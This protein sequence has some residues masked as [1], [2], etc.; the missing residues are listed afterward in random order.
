M[1]ARWRRSRSTW[2]VDPRRQRDGLLAQAVQPGQDDAGHGD[3]FLQLGG[4]T[5]GDHRDDR[6]ALDQP[7]DR[8]AG[9][10][11]DLGELGPGHDGAE[12]AVEIEQHPGA[13][14]APC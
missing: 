4:G 5:P 10:V 14:V 9:A 11:A 7:G 3:E 2:S 13:A 6:E 8:I 12:G 1:P